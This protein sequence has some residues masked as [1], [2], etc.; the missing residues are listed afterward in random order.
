MELVGLEELPI[1]T[2]HIE[3]ELADGGK[4]AL[5]EGEDFLRVALYETNRELRDAK[6][7]PFSRLDRNAVES[8]IAAGEHLKSLVT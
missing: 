6:L 7:Y 8:W 4:A 5:E 3:T 1:I 2:T